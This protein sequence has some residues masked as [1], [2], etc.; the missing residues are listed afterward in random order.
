[1]MKNKCVHQKQEKR[2]KRRMC[3]WNEYI[4]EMQQNETQWWKWKEMLQSDWLTNLALSI[5]QFSILCQRDLLTQSFNH[6][7][8][9][10]I[11]WCECCSVR[12]KNGSAIMIVINKS[13]HI[14]IC[15]LLDRYFVLFDQYRTLLRWFFVENFSIFLNWM[16]MRKSD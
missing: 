15:S 1:M 10:V 4:A 13:V 6:S 3:K 5:S 2:E 14:W 9:H 11:I 8:T 16:K 12:T 7:I